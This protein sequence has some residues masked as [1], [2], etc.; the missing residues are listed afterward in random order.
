MLTIFPGLFG[1]SLQNIEDKIKYLISI[2]L[3]EVVTNDPKQLMQSVSVAYARYEFLKS[4][5][6]TPTS[7][8]YYL[9]F[10]DEPY[11]KKRFHVTK[12]ELIQIYDYKKYKEQTY[13]KVS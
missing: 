10:S 1:F 13:G 7:D 11:F 8:D 6:L 12:G 9:L 2:N 4:K 5:D 3:K